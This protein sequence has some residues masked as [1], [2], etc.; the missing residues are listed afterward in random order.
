VPVDGEF[1][2]GE[3]PDDEN[4][5][6]MFGNKIVDLIQDGIIKD[7]VMGI[8]E[9][10]YME[11]SDAKFII[12]VGNSLLG[13]KPKKQILLEPELESLKEWANGKK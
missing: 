6:L 13:N 8:C 5:V 4:K 12:A 7:A 9:K 10:P 1:E 2:F 3:I 11:P